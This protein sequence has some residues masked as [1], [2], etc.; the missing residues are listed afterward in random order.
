MDRSSSATMGAKPSMGWPVPLKTRPITS[1]EHATAAPSLLQRDRRTLDV[2]APRSLKNLNHRV[3]RGGFEHLP[4]PNLTAVHGQ[5]QDGAG[6]EP[7]AVLKKH[8]R[9]RNVVQVPVFLLEASSV[10]AIWFTPSIERKSRP[11]NSLGCYGRFLDP[12]P[13][14]PPSYP[15]PPASILLRDKTLC[16]Q[17]RADRATSSRMG[18][19]RSASRLTPCV[20]A[21]WHSP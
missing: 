5:V 1:F 2:D 6:R 15:A 7:A 14:A 4:L 10:S 13:E 18:C 20:S 9:A 11:A 16:V 21:N 17:L 12:D 3:L 19:S 8:E